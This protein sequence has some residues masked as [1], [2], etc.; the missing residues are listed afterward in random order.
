MIRVALA[1]GFALSLG[2]EVAQSFVPG[3]SSSLIDLASNSAGALLG[4]LLTRL[5][6]WV[7]ALF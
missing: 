3:R 4:A 1:A 2:I 7:R 6:R 5:P